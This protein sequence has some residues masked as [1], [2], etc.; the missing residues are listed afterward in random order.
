VDR[1][2]IVIFTQ[3][4]S[5]IFV[6]YCRGTRDGIIR[7]ITN[8]HHI[9]ISIE[10]FGK[11]VAK[12]VPIIAAVEISINQSYNAIDWSVSYYRIVEAH[13][14]NGRVMHAAMSIQKNIDD[15]YL[16]LRQCQ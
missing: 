3:A 7:Q 13:N 16:A 11:W 2:S 15:T 14:I 4:E 9:V 1:F 8:L 5:E 6:G 10:V 12:K